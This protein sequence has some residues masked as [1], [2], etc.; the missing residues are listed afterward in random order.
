MLFYSRLELFAICVTGFHCMTVILGRLSGF[1][2]VRDL[3]Q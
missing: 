1:S 3:L 2:Y